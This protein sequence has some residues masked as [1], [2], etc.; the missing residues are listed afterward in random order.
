MECLERARKIA[1]TVV[2]TSPENNVL[3]VELLNRYMY[4]FDAGTE[5]LTADH[6][7]GLMSLI[8]EHAGQEGESAGQDVFFRNT[9]LG[10]RKKA[11][12]NPEKYAGLGA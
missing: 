6:L 8:R 11:S 1:D 4:F 5:A 7:N 10:L 3:L 2:A 12:E 9:R